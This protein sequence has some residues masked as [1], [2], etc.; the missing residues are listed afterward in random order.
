MDLQ[1]ISQFLA[2]NSLAVLIIIV[3][4]WWIGSLVTPYFKTKLSKSAKNEGELED[5]IITKY[6][7]RMDST[8]KN[9]EETNVKILKQLDKINTTNE[10]ISVTN[11]E[12]SRTNRKL[13]EG[14]EG[15][16]KGIEDDLSVIK[17]RI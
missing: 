5:K 8:I 12:L 17:E 13:V 9:Q 10:K 1:T 7:E 16:L 3:I 15:R 4:G 14:Y 6:F 2:T 11:E